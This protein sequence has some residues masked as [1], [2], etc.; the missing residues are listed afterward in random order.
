MNRSASEARTGVGAAEPMQT[1]IL[2]FS[3]H[4]ERAREQTA[5]TIALRVPTLAYCWG[6]VARGILKAEINSFGRRPFLFGP[7][8]NS[9]TGTRRVPSVEES[10]TS[11]FET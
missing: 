8:M 5:I 7:V 3:G 6:P 1:P 9:D 4:R 2:R 10:S 11:A